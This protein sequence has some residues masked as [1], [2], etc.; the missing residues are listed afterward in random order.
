MPQL[1]TIHILPKRHTRRLPQPSRPR[2]HA[3]A[4]VLAPVLA[5]RTRSSCM[6]W[7]GG[8]CFAGCLRRV[9]EAS[10]H[11]LAGPAA[12]QGL[13]A[14]AHG[15]CALTS[16]CGLTVVLWR[17][18]LPSRPVRP[19]SGWGHY[20]CG[21]VFRGRPRCLDVR[22][23]LEQ[24]Y[25]QPQVRQPEPEQ[26]DLE[27]DERTH[28]PG[29]CPSQPAAS[30]TE[31]R[32]GLM[33]EH[34]APKQSHEGRLWRIR[35]RGDLREHLMLPTRLQWPRPRLREWGPCSW[36]SPAPP[37]VA[38]ETCAVEGRPEVHEEGLSA[39]LCTP[40]NRFPAPPT[41]GGSAADGA[42]LERSSSSCARLA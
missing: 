9:D 7:S 37:S 42:L 3:S 13:G 32:T 8:G 20:S 16:P 38:R 34:Q 2:Q 35:C 31:P 11:V 33:P 41:V 14:N 28:L 21:Q 15:A 12:R 29:G 6:G 27:L 17:S 19:R 18:R 26:D 39:A 30:P 4:A 25:S 40:S 1:E 23:D 10:L 22:R 5:P 24:S 36:S